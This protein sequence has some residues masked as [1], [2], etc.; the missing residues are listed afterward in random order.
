MEETA[1]VLRRTA[2][3]WQL[4]RTAIGGPRE[5]A[6]KLRRLGRTVGLYLRPAEITERLERLRA[7]GLV[8]EIPERNQ[9]LFGGIDMLRFVISPFA[10]EYYA[11]K[12]ISFGFHQLLRILDDPVSMID[13][14]G[15]LSDRDTI[16]GHVMQVVHLNPVYDL[17]LVQMF[18][19]GLEDLERQVEA[20]VEGRHPRHRTISAIVEDPDY[21][22]RLLDYVRRYRADPGTAPLTR[23]EQTLRSDPRFAAAERTFATLPGFIEYCRRLPRELGALAPRLAKVRQF[24]L[25]L[26]GGR[27]SE[28]GLRPG[29]LP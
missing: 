24:P 28:P 27:E 1:E 4:V 13:P 29:P 11:S 19:D 8:D 2:S 17:Q 6:G 9:I 15:F 20:M 7:A 21:H 14:T 10:R 18:P 22:A 25:E 5:V 3:P 12:G 16:V 26:A 23:Q